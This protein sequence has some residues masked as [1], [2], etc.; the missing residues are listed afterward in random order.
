M[1]CLF[2]ILSLF[3]LTA[4]AQVNP[5]YNGFN[6]KGSGVVILTDIFSFSS[7]SRPCSGCTN[8][9][10]NP[11]PSGSVRTGTG[12]HGTTITSVATANYIE[13]GGTSAFDG[14]GSNAGV[15]FTNCNGTS[16]AVMFNSWFTGSQYDHTKPQLQLGNL[17]TGK[18]YTIKI[19]GSS[20]GG[21]A[22]SRIT[23]IHIEGAT[24]LSTQTYNPHPVTGGGGGGQNTTDG[25]T[26]TGVVPDGSGT[27]RIWFNKVNSGDQQGHCGVIS[28]ANEN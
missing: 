25:V 28:I 23:L 1:R 4:N 5:G 15:F 19:T 11:G 6:N 3:C 2:F 27:I 8:I 14:A 9:A 26:F 10:G 13:N 22:T 7:A 24:L 16:N 17:S 18:T 12:I 21:N 20:T